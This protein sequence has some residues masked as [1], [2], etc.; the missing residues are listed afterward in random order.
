MQDEIPEHKLLLIYPLPT[1][2]AHM[3]H[4]LSISHMYMGVNTKRYIFSTWFLLL[5]AVSYG[6]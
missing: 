6:W 1:N 2:D 4:G 3:C 5:F